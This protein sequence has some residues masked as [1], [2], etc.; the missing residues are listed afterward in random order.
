MKALKKVDAK[1]SGIFAA[2][3]LFGTAGIKVLTSKDAKKVYTCCTAAV[4]RAKDCIMNVAAK[5]QDNAG[6]IYAEAQDVYKRQGQESGKRSGTENVPAIAGF[7]LAAEMSE[8]GRRENSASMAQMR[9]RLISQLTASLDNIVIN[10]PE[11]AGENAGE[12]CS[13]L[14]NI[15]FLGTRGE[16]LLHTLE[17][18]GIYVSTGSACSSNKKG[19]SHVLKAMGLKDKEIEG[20]LRFS[21]GRMNSIE[22]IDIAADKVAAAVK[23]FRRLGSFR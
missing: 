7:G 11:T 21:F 12:C 13:S 9:Q 17:Q 15:S 5:A 4:L 2:G 18:D 1:K 6:D 23:R 3:V 20:T 8:H 16:V 22:E 10:S 14:L 19:Q